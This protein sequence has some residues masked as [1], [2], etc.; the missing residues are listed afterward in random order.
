MN[1]KALL[2]ISCTLFGCTLGPDY[3][4]PDTVS[5]K[6]IDASL[7]VTPNND[8]SINADWH[9]AFGDEQLDEL[10][11][12]AL[13]DSPT[14]KIAVEKLRQARLNL[15]IQGVQYYPTVDLAG[16][17]TKLKPSKTHL[18]LLRK[19]IIRPDWT[20]HGNSI[21]GAPAGGQRK[22]PAPWPKP[23]PPAWITSA[24]R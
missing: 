24:S 2:L 15:E 7:S 6:Q 3:K 17:Y 11:Q 19:V 1:K 13:A 21:S 22:T 18:P 20:F 8:T 10:I 9:K 4:R 12:I 5:D 23:P 16:E 14:V